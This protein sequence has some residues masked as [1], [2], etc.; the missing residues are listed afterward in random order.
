MAVLLDVKDLTK[1]FGGLA[2]VS[3]VNMHLDDNELVALIGPNG[4]G[5]T[6]LF[7]LITGQ[8]VPS[9]GSISLRTNN[10][11]MQVLNGKKP[12]KIADMGLARTFQNIRLFKGLSVL[13]NVLI[14]MTSKNKEGFISS[15]FRLPS[16]YKVEDRLRKEALDLLAIF[17]M[18][19]MAETIAS[20]MPYG[21]QRR[22]EIIRALATKPKILFL[23]EPAA[24][25][26]PEETA[27]LTATI[28]QIQQE[29]GITVLLIEHD[30]SL[31]MNVAERIYV[32]QYGKLLAEGTPQEIQA[33]QAVVDAYLGGGV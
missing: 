2:A 6:T 14:S 22:L 21:A 20:N 1:N 8:T 23:D 19:D 27:A 3:D 16:F 7:N 28:R 11:G 31:V 4:A 9:A 32:L 33:N 24:G 29:F 5:K 26:N 18:E 10:E 13:D 30:M 12:Y 17:H 15:L 25:M